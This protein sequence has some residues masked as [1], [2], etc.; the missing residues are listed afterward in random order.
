MENRTIAIKGERVAL[1]EMIQEDQ[2][3]F[4]QWLT[5]NPL[6]REQID[7]DRIPTEAEQNAWFLRSK[8]PDR[9]MF[10]V[11]VMADNRLIG[12]AG[13]VDINTNLQSAQFRITLGDSSSHGKG[14]GTEVITLLLRYAFDVMRLESVWL[15]VLHDNI[16]A[17]HVY[18]K[19]GFIPSQVQESDEPR[20]LRMTITRSI[21]SSRDAA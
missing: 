10:S 17:I 5:D 9:K 6:L 3:F 8:E 2:P 19:V 13:F 11:I 16:R 1:A 20:A 14:Y 21:F 4:R 18:E 15:R 7:N 12:N